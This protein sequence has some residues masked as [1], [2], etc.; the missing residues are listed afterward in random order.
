MMTDDDLDLIFAAARTPGVPSDRLM[1]RVLAD[2][3]AAQPRG[4]AAVAQEFAVRGPEPARRG[5]LASIFAAMGGG[6]VVAGLASAVVAGLFIGYS[7]PVTT[8]WLA[9]IV[10]S[11]AQVEMISASDL[12]LSE[13]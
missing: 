6:A 10:S 12:F 4:A 2:A 9:G 13:G 1:A 8:D 5:L 7:G 11:G 3:D